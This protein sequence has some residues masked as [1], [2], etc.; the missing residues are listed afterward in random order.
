MTA[1]PWWRDSRKLGWL[2]QAAVGLGLLVVVAL[3]LSNLEQNLT[4]AGLRLTLGWLN[5]PA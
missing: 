3:L 4:R 2:V 1:L 5:Q